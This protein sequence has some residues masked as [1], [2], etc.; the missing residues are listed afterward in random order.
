MREV[1]ESPDA[2]L[3]LVETWVHI[4]KDNPEAADKYIDELVEKAQF[5]AKSRTPGVSEPII[6]REIEEPP[7]RVRSFLYRN[8]RCIFLLTDTQMQILAYL[9]TRRD[10]DRAL[11]ERLKRL[12]EEVEKV[13][14]S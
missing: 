11:R 12:R 1:V 14:D 10:R 3:D 7:E 13:E 2:R 6:A 5:W 8:H 9:D 4:A